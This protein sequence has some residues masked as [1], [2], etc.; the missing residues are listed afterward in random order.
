M[1][2]W[3]VASVVACWRLRGHGARMVDGAKDSRRRSPRPPGPARRAQTR[4]QRLHEGGDYATLVAGLVSGR[5]RALE[6]YLRGL[7]MPDLVAL[8]S[9]LDVDAQ[10]VEA[11]EVVR[12]YVGP[13]VRRRLEERTPVTSADFTI[14][15][16]S[17]LGTA[18]AMKLPTPLMG[19][20]RPPMRLGACGE[21]SSSYALQSNDRGVVAGL[22]AHRRWM[23]VRYRARPGRQ[24]V[25][26]PWRGGAHRR[27]SGRR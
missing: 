15:L 4:R 27:R 3:Q 20:T 21:S 5:T 22:P 23:R 26:S 6:A 10:L 13:E 25:R 14:G 9:E 24:G 16:P 1:S 19:R 18:R 17:P 8:L 7:G 11:L 2:G 12:S